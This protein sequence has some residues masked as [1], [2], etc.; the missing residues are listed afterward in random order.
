VVEADGGHVELVPV[1]EGASTTAIVEKIARLYG[2][3]EG[4]G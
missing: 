4:E 1:V 3:A 2:K